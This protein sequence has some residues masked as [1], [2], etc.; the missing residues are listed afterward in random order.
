[1]TSTETSGRTSVTWL[2]GAS[3]DTSSP[4]SPR[5]SPSAA[6]AA[7]APTTTRPPVTSAVRSARRT[8]V[9][10]IVLSPAQKGVAHDGAGSRLPRG[11]RRR[12]TSGRGNGDLEERRGVRRA[13][14]VADGGPRRA[15]GR[16]GAETEGGDVAARAAAV[17]APGRRGGRSRGAV[18]GDAGGRRRPARGGGSSDR[19]DGGS[20]R[21][22]VVRRPRGGELVGA[23]GRGGIRSW[24]GRHRGRR[25]LGHE[26]R[27]GGRGV[28]GRPGPRGVGPGH[29]GQH[30]RERVDGRER[31]GDRAEHGVGD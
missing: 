29:V 30:G 16:V 13:R 6:W 4:R 18:R 17:H 14:V 31:A 11:A 12:T 2:S 5:T 24:L 22:G 8:K 3:T 7:P 28:P 23:G 19:R 26:R 20:H 21:G 27:R 25:V 10:I 1:G 9:C 15:S